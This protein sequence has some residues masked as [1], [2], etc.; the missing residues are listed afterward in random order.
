L[1]KNV[2]KLQAAREG[3]FLTHTVDKWAWTKWTKSVT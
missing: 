1:S 2:R 3:D